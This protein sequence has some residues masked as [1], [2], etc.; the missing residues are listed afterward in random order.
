M[1]GTRGTTLQGFLTFLLVYAAARLGK[2]LVGASISSALAP[3]GE[4]LPPSAPLCPAGDVGCDGEGEV[5]RRKARLA[6]A[7]APGNSSGEL[8]GAPRREGALAAGG[9]AAWPRGLPRV[10]LGLSS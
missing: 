7:A 6:D 9:L 8:L 3:A 1:G 5:L 2:E 10:A 4:P